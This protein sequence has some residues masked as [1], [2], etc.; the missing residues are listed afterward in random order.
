M[1]LGTGWCASWRYLPEGGYPVF[2]NDSD[3]LY[4]ADRIRECMNRCLVAYES[5]A[6]AGIGNEGFYD[7]RR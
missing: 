5:G 3:P 2:L 6:A 1:L 7:N 4:D